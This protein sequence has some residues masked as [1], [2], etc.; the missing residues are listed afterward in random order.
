MQVRTKAFYVEVTALL[1]FAL[2]Q[3][4][5]PAFN[6]FLVSGITLKHTSAKWLPV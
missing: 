5:A 2:I 6:E 3:I 1:L 4:P